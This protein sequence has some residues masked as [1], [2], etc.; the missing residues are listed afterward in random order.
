MVNRRQFMMDSSKI[1]VIFG[2]T[3]ITPFLN[4]CYGTKVIQATEVE[5]QVMVTK[6]DFEGLK[7]VMIETDKLQA[8]LLVSMV[9]EVGYV[10]L[11]MECTHKGCNVHPAGEVIQC[12]CHGSQFSYT[13]EVL[14]RPATDPLKTYKVSVT[15]DNIY[16]HLDE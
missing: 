11:L 5:G 1:A 14:K 7:Y 15:G 2:I 4:G 6:S 9:E 16:V 3:G 10:A 8:P 12:G 13:G